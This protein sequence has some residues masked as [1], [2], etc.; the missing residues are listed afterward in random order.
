M[1]IGPG[2]DENPRVD[3]V[4]VA[5]KPLSPVYVREEHEEYVRLLEAAV[6][7]P[8]VKTDVAELVRGLPHNIAVTGHYGSGK[9][10][11][12]IEAQRRLGARAITIALSSLGADDSPPGRMSRS[13][14]LPP[15]T[16]LIQKEIVKQLLYRKAP[17]QMRGSRYQRIDSFN[18][19]PAAAWS[20]AV[21]VVF[22][23]TTTLVGLVHG[24]EREFPGAEASHHHWLAWVLLCALSVG[25][26][27]VAFGGQRAIYDRM[28]ITN[29]TAGPAAIALSKRENSYFDEYLDEIVFFFQRS[30]T[31]VVI[32]EDL[33][34]FKDP[35]IFEALRELN[36]VLNDAEQL[37][38]RPVQFVYALRDSVFDQ[39][40]SSDDTASPG[41]DDASDRSAQPDYLRRRSWR[42]SASSNRTKFFDLVIPI[43]PFLSLRTSR[44]LLRSQFLD[45]EPKPSDQVIDVVANYLTDMRLIK[46]ICNEYVVYAK[47]LLPPHGLDGLHADQLFAMTVYKN[48][49]ME[50]YERIREGTSAIDQIFRAAKQVIDDQTQA[51][52]IRLAAARA[53]LRTLEEVVPRAREL[54]EQLTAIVA[55]LGPH[56]PTIRYQVQGH[57]FTP[58]QLQLPEFWQ[59][60]ASTQSSV[61]ITSGQP[62]YQGSTRVISFQQLETILGTKLAPDAWLE[63]K[64]AEYNSDLTT[65]TDLRK[66]ASGATVPELFA[67]PDLTT[68]RSGAAQCLSQIADDLLPSKLA[69]ALIRDALIDQNYILYIASFGGIAVSSSAMNFILQVVQRDESDLRYHFD[70]PSSID[71]VLD[72]EGERFLYSA[73]VLNIEVFDHLLCEKPTILA[74]GIR[75]LSRS[76][77]LHQRFIAAYLSEGRH[78]EVLI[79]RLAGIWPGTFTYLVAR[80]DARD[81]GGVRFLNAALEGVS[82]RTTYESNNGVTDLI[83]I[84]SPAMPVFTEPVQPQ[85]ADAVVAFLL[86]HGIMIDP[87][88]TVPE[89]MRAALVVTGTYRLT[90]ANV[91]AAAGE[92]SVALDVVRTH[93]TV[94]QHLLHHLG[95]YLAGVVGDAPTIESTGS[96]AA[97]LNDAA[98]A[99]DLPDD[100]D[101]LRG[102]AS[103]AADDCMVDDLEEL[104]PPAWNAVVATGRLKP[105]GV[106]LSRYIAEV[107]IDSSLDAYLE[108]TDRLV[109]PLG[110]PEGRIGLAQEILNDAA[111]SPDHRLGL[112]QS[113]DLGAHISL[114]NLDDNAHQLLPELV[115]DDVIED[116]AAVWRRLEQADWRARERLASVSDGFAAYISELTIGSGDARMIAESRRIPADKKKLLLE[117]LESISLDDRAASAIARLAGRENISLSIEQI[118]SLAR[119]G[120]DPDA[121]VDGMRPMLPTL[122]RDDAL[123]VVR[124]LPD[125]YPMLA[126]TERKPIH[127]PTAA[128]PLLERL[129][130]L[131]VVSSYKKRRKADEFA[132][133]TH[134]DSQPSADGAE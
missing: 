58:D 16:N 113:L 106:N 20:L 13:G 2:K 77:R 35:H 133:F 12:L 24:I 100:Y 14:E 26:G 84:A 68:S 95:D 122:S 67:A 33:D 124:Q 39:L 15:L 93:E 102:V 130:A 32:F 38:R 76:D 111:I 28:S 41:R 19:R 112:V 134:R 125:P 42:V 83:G 64:R 54:G 103:R 52:E 47:R 31:D 37:T 132:V 9:S 116:S 48:E 78:P 75:R 81:P 94:Y 49:H 85:T 117:H 128:A 70:D 73:A 30:K 115:R 8:D 63:E 120:G 123:A 53:G 101:Q 92:A 55:V 17:R 6:A 126:E 27:G 129:R 72:E 88:E 18:W 119:A 86:E 131:G 62:G 98:E 57:T 66:R 25:A 1:S 22:L 36:T 108:Q 79:R 91:C 3:T 44:D 121:V 40:D 74:D 96:F 50:D 11:V 46:N 107:G 71:Q 61:A 99:L 29:I 89:P 56:P 104:V 109:E 4:L 118:G 21:A 80:E 82:E 59:R 65:A 127:L 34:R 60:V 5:L 110:E 45:V 114:A 90:R 105:T 51:A 23:V 87:L 7:K 97:V 10:S 43:V 69:V